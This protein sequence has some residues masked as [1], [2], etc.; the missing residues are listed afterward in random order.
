MNRSELLQ[1]IVVDPNTAGGK[2]CV[3]GTRIYVATILDGMAEG[4]TPEQ[5]I[6][7]Y[8]QLTLD[9]IRAA[10]AYGGELAQEN[11]WKLAV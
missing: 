7:H 4:L 1:R 2:P 11:T 6:E 10:L 8:P 3:R 9:D 5:L